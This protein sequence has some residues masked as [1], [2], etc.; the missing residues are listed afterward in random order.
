MN[1]PLLSAYNRE[2][3]VLCPTLAGQMP[4]AL[5]PLSRRR[6]GIIGCVGQNLLN[7]NKVLRSK[8]VH[9]YGRVFL[10]ADPTIL[11]YPEELKMVD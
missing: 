1:R 11:S 2:T 5:V 9:L 10:K 4:G 3:P 8:T 7:G 6:T